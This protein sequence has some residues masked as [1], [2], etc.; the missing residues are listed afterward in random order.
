MLNYIYQKV[1]AEDKADFKP[2]LS[3]G[4]F[5]HSTGRSRHIILGLA[6]LSTVLS[7]PITIAYFRNSAP[8][9]P[10][11]GDTPEIARQRG[12]SFDLISFAWQ[13][14]ECYD[15]DLVSEFANW[16]RWSFYTDS[17]GNVTISEVAALA[18]ERSLWVTWNYHI[19]HCTF[20]WRQM[21]RAY[22]RGWIDAHLRSYNH[23]LHCQ[24]M[25]LKKG[26]EGTDVGTT[27]GLIYP[28]CD[29]VRKVRQVNTWDSVYSI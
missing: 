26:V 11:C 7:F 17:H 12:C 18:G 16:D 27:A 6:V 14:P 28:V 13:T 3:R 22:K 4:I 15:S 1:S 10:S 21:H 29:S 19:V 8:T 25:L 9:W 20:M 23:T 5:T 24:E 2:T